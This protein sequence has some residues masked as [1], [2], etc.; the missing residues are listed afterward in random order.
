MKR[1]I[2]YFKGH[3]WKPFWSIILKQCGTRCERCGKTINLILLLIAATALA[4]QATELY[5]PIGQ[6]PGLSKEGKTVIGYV[7]AVTNQQV[8]ISNR[9][10]K[11]DAKTWFYLDRSAVK[12]TNTYGGATNVVTNAFVEAWAPTN[13]IA[14]W[15]KIRSR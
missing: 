1:L 13:G 11:L 8:T 3:Q 10:V 5:I 4:Q 6:S 15:V 2:C 7:T 9:V 12:R 14:N